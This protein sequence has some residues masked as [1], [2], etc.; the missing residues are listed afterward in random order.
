MHPIKPCN[1]YTARPAGQALYRRDRHAFKIYY[2]DIVG[3]DRPERYAKAA[4]AADTVIVDLEDA[5]SPAE[6]PRARDTLVAAADAAS[7]D[8]T[9]TIVRVNP[10]STE[11]FARDLEAIRRTPYT[12]LMLAKAEGTAQLDALASAGTFGVV[13]LCET[14]LG[15]VRAAE[16]AAHPSVVGMMW[17][18][19]DLIAS[20]AGRTSRFADEL[21]AAAGLPPYSPQRQGLSAWLAGVGTGIRHHAPRFLM[22]LRAFWWGFRGLGLGLMVY[23]LW[24]SVP[25]AF[26]QNEYFGLWSY[27]VSSQN[28]VDTVVQYWGWADHLALL[29]VLLVLGLLVSVWVGGLQARGAGPRW[30]ATLVGVVGV[31]LGIYLASVFWVFFTEGLGAIWERQLL[32]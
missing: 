16:I 17:G 3:R 10:A 28:A 8:P 20:M 18:A 23:V 9:R 5:V 1:P 12:T 31:L 27:L 21:R 26:S 14:A 7:L 6:K 13:A 2:V 11:D 30:L 24:L 22:D 4:A 32:P 25:V 15:V 29:C 19:E